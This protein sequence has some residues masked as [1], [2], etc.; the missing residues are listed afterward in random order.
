MNS[1][2]R[3]AG[4]QVFVSSCANGR[5]QISLSDRLSRA[6]RRAVDTAANGTWRIIARRIS[7]PK[8]QVALASGREF[9]CLRRP[10]RACYF[11][12]SV[13]DDSSV[14]VIHPDQLLGVRHQLRDY[15]Y[16]VIVIEH[17]LDVITTADW[18]VDLG[19]EGG[20][21]GG[22][23]VVEGTPEQVAAD[24][25]SHTGRFLRHV[26]G[27]ERMGRVSDIAVRCGDKRTASYA[28]DIL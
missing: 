15:G 12:R 27:D 9:A 17:N 11:I 13:S 4:I 8:V 2:I 26:L 3:G 18:I 24:P 19:P 22:R 20:D 21:G 23:I 14:P 25:H 28:A 7:N 10:L 6:Y 16:T 5:I 1:L